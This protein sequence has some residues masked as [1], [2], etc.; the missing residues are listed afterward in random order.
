[1]ED[2]LHSGF[3]ID[4]AFVK[5]WGYIAKK[6]PMLVD[7]FPCYS[8][9]FLQALVLPPSDPNKKQLVTFVDKVLHNIQQQKLPLREH[10]SKDQII[11]KKEEK[12]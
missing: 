10:I 2:K 12:S 9:S 1:M 4:T 3:V 7:V 6:T 11:E 8:L 5:R